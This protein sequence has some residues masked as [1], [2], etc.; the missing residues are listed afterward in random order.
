MTEYDFE[1]IWERIY[2][3]VDLHNFEKAT[4]QK[5]RL[6]AFKKALSRDD[7]AKNFLRSGKENVQKL[8]EYGIAQRVAEGDE[9]AISSFRR[10]GET[11]RHRISAFSGKIKS[12]NFIDQALD[13]AEAKGFAV[14]EFKSRKSG[15]GRPSK[16]MIQSPRITVKRFKQGK[17]E[18]VGVWSKGRKGLVTKIIVK[19]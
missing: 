9:K 7:K 6:S 3:K 19:E 15:L 11:K 2:K 13:K 16:T 12:E 8:F 14:R 4:N 1:E 17:N 10:F 18:Y 5:D